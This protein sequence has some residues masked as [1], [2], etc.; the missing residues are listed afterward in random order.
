MPDIN[1]DLARLTADT[2]K[3]QPL[4]P[5]SLEGRT[6]RETTLKRAAFIDA[7]G[8][9][10]VAEFELAK[11]DFP[12]GST[13]IGDY[14]NVLVPKLASRLPNSSELAA[15]TRRFMPDVED[16]MARLN[17]ALR[18]WAGY[19]DAAKIAADSTAEGNNT[20]QTREAGMK[21]AVEPRAEADPLYAAGVV[22]MPSLKHRTKGEVIVR[23]GI[24]AASIVFRDWDDWRT[25]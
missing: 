1:P 2:L 4:L 23:D 21:N 6:L 19:I 24:P 3:V 8:N 22:A 11:K 10:L 15:V 7:V 18:M 12:Q 17:I 9:P 20:P 25:G 16:F 5:I 13:P 14:P